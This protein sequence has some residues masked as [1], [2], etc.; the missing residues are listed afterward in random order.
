GV[1]RIHLPDGLKDRANLQEA[2][3]IARQAATA[4]AMRRATEAGAKAIE[5]SLSEAIDEIDLG[6]DKSLFLQATLT[7]EASGIPT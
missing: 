5:T 1:F 4:M 3:D 6:A 2:L 7:A